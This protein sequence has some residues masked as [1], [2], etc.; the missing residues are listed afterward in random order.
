MSVLSIRGYC[1]RPSAAP[2]ETLGFHVSSDEPG[3]YT[4]ELVRLI[5]GDLDPAGPGPREDVIPH[6]VNGAY[7]ARNQ[8]TQAG[9]YVEIPDLRGALA[10]TDGLSVHAFVSSM[11]PTRGRQGL[12]S[13]WDAERSE[14]WALIVDETGALAFVVGD[15]SGTTGVVRSDRPLFEDTFYSVMAAYDAA[16]GTLTLHQKSVV[17]STNSRFGKVFPL[18]SDTVVSTNTSVRPTPAEVPVLL[19]GLSEAA[20]AG[21]IWVVGNFNG[22]I[23]SPS[24]YGAALDTT[25][26]ERMAAGERV[27]ASSVLARWDFAAGIGP[28]GVP[29]DVIRDVSGNGLHG[30][31]VN[32]PDLAMT[33]RNWTGRT[34]HFV[35]APEQYGA[36][37]FHEDSLDDSRWERDF[38]LTIPDDLPSGC[39]AVRLRQGPH[40]DQVPFF[41]VPPRGTATARVL[42][43]IPTVS[44]LAYANSQVMQNAPSAQA[45]MGH[46]GVLEDT[47][48]ELNERPQ[49]YGLS[50]YDYHLD[51]RGCQY[52]SWRRPILNM[53]PRYRHEFGSVWQFPADLQLVDWLTAQGFEFDVATDHDLMA[54]GA[55]LFRRYNVVVTGSH[56]EYYTREMIDAWEDYL[57][58]GGRGM[59]LAGN[60]MYWIASQHPQ[61]P[62]LMEI[63]KGESGDQAWRARPGELHHSTSGER[64]GLWRMR[65]RASAKVWGVV[66]TSHGLDVSTGFVQMPDARE[67][68][69]EWMFE[70]VGPD[71]TIGDFGLVGG[72]AA[73]L[74]VDRYDQ[75]LGTPPNTRLVASSYGH[76]PNWGLVP[77]EQYFVHSGMNGPEH[78]LVRGDITYFS[79]RNGGAMFASS[80]MAWCASLSWNDYQNNVSLLT[81]NVL[82][83]FAAD[84][85]LEEV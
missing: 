36:I 8:R 77:E 64:G 10:G 72:G 29:T 20:S 56:P 74:E 17:N 14:G 65:A 78:P 42:L 7:G 80:S 52:T 48:L 61:K 84:G 37:W 75:A 67:P 19:A 63:R 25:A 4:A 60:G 45:I 69:L 62:W 22:K 1:D 31:C 76:T 71:E 21:R 18:D 12:V 47:D 44:Y 59:Y 73:G 23:D 83:R 32:Q 46:V 38:E 51:G 27:A 58:E 81:G 30:T 79:T 35:H 6:E 68:R 16:T 9:G 33:G 40:E 41:V 3:E 85:P 11:T 24:V 13:R 70:G 26:A 55:D 54:E 15:G 49:I 82:R 66:Y 2:G 34:E 43:L 28:D 50:T 57:A 5:N 53:R 39:Y